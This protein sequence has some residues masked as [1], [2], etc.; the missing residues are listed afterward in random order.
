MPISPQKVPQVKSCFQSYVR[1]LEESGFRVMVITCDGAS[2]NRK[3]FKMHTTQNRMGTVTYKT[4]NPYSPD[5]RDVY[6]VSDVPHL[7]K[8][9]HNCWS[10]SFGHSNTRAL[11]VSDI[12]LLI[13]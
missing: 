3:F 12:I 1:N 6:F 4:K 2:P 5:G 10:N 11:W 9:T 7:I 8:T 13:W